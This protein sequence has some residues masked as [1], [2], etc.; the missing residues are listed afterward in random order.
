MVSRLD[1][2]LAQYM[3]FIIT[4]SCY[5]NA[6]IGI[7]LMYLLY[8]IALLGYSAPS[9]SRLVEGKGLVESSEM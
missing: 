8:I 4:D 7:L 2:T 5:F 1:S 6:Q 3:P 9:L